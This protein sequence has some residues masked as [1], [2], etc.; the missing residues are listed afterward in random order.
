MASGPSTAWWPG[1]RSPREPDP[2][3]PKPSDR[4]AD[5]N[6]PWRRVTFRAFSANAPEARPPPRPD[7]GTGVICSSV[8][9]TSI[10]LA[11]RVR[12]ALD[13]TG[14]TSPSPAVVTSLL[15]IRGSRERSGFPSRRKHR[16]TCDDTSRRGDSNPEPP[17]YKRSEIGITASIPCVPC[18]RNSIGCPLRHLLCRA[19]VTNLV[20]REALM[21]R[22]EVRDLRRRPC[23][24]RA[25]KLRAA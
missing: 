13:W 4:R 15:Q 6:C 16:L 14:G 21:I 22:V 3:R 8:A 20:R 9:N 25:V 2:V 24:S 23:R 7:R 5:A 10:P 11:L 12:T 17:V 19:F 1:P 18:S